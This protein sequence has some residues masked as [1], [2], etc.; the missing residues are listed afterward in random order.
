M[1]HIH[2][3]DLCTKERY[4]ERHGMCGTFRFDYSKNEESLTHMKNM[5][6]AGSVGGFHRKQVLSYFLPPLACV[7]ES[8][9]LEQ[10]IRRVFRGRSLDHEPTGMTSPTGL[11]WMRVPRQT[12]LARMHTVS[13]KCECSITICI[14]EN[15]NA[16]IKI[17]LI[18]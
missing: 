9:A 13:R 14:G 8:S 5:S 6:P 16:R 3:Y 1:A 7:T 12:P 15:V 4:T 11:A 18:E 2:N 17:L 10:V